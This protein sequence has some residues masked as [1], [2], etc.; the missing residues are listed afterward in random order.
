MPIGQRRDI[1]GKSHAQQIERVDFACGVRETEEINGAPAIFEQGLQRGF[2]TVLC[3]I[4]EERIAG[5]ERKKSEGDAGVC[6]NV[7]E[8]AVEDFVSSAVT[9]DSDEAAIVLVVGFAGE[10]CGVTGTGRGDDVNAK[11]ACAQARD[12]WADEFGRAATAGGGVD[13]GEERFSHKRASL[14]PLAILLKRLSRSAGAAALRW[15]VSN[16]G[17]EWLDA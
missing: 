7:S 11:A 5:T 17:A 1:G 13:D 16:V 9:A 10:V 3:E 8:D 2:G 4:A 6:C 14:L 12:G 15:V